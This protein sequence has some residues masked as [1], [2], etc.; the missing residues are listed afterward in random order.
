ML[1]REFCAV[2][3]SPFFTEF[4]VL[5][6]ST[7]PFT[8]HEHASSNNSNARTSRG[9]LSQPPQQR[10]QFA[11]LKVTYSFARFARAFFIFVY[12]AA[13]LVFSTTLN[14]LL[15]SCLDY[16]TTWPQV[17]SFSS[18]LQIAHRSLIWGS[19]QTEY[20]AAFAPEC[21]LKVENVISISKGKRIKHRLI[22]LFLV[23][24]RPGKFW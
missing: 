5:R 2:W 11:Y 8:A 22:S 1:F 13:F 4:E 20:E 17:S 24:L 21:G 15:C 10:Q 16:E 3:S 12:F 14:D 7:V 19:F 23:F 18:H 9:E 6:S